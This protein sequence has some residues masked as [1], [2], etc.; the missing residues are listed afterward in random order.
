M[1]GR[2]PIERRRYKRFSPRSSAF[3]AF[4]AYDKKI[5]HIVDISR[6]GL[7]FHYFAN[8]DRLNKSVSIDIYS[9]EEGFYLKEVPFITVSDVELPREFAWSSIIMRRRGIQF[10]NLTPSQVSQVEYFLLNHTARNQ[11][12]K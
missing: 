5:G 10:D 9:A 4:G 11:N 8:G 3:V 12:M 7:A 6:G 1:K 2:E